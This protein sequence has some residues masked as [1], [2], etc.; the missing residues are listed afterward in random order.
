MLVNGEH[1]SVECFRLIQKVVCEAQEVRRVVLGVEERYPQVAKLWNHVRTLSKGGGAR[2]KVAERVYT[3][4]DQTGKVGAEAVGNQIH[5][6]LHKRVEV[7][8]QAVGNVGVAGQTPVPRVRQDNERQRA[9]HRH[10]DIYI[11]LLWEIC[12]HFYVCKIGCCTF[13]CT[14]HV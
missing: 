9:K 1:P 5:V 7:V 10:K 13:K 6:G 14:V 11:I 2:D 12:V 3:L 8:C 4:P